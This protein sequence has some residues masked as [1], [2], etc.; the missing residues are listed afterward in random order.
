MTDEELKDLVASNAK[1]IL[2]LR[3]DIKETSRE[4]KKTSKY[5]K[6]SKEETDKFI[7]ETSMQMK[8]TEKQ[9]KETAIQ[10][11]ET[12]RK[13][14]SVGVQLGNIGANQGD[15]AEEFFVNS[16]SNLKVCGI[17]YDELHKNMHKRVRKNEGEF[18][19]VLINGVDIAIIET[20][21]KAHEDDLEDLIENKHKKFKE[22]YPEY[23]DYNHHLGLASFYM[24]DELKTRALKNNVFVLQ[25]KGELIESF[26]P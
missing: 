19:I 2:E 23:N 5:L 25:R 8:E 22:L 12:D 21:Y 14:K 13:L 4:V 1:A 17:Q 3:E 15:I 18:D 10:M 11:K 20:K 7:K 16:L 6:K 9:L 24:S 26:L